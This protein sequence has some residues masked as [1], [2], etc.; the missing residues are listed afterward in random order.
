MNR[1]DIEFW[2]GSLKTA[3]LIGKEIDRLMDRCTDKQIEGLKLARKKV[4]E[5]KKEIEDLNSNSVKDALQSV[6]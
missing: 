6:V 4:E 5:I 1:F 2:N 3:I